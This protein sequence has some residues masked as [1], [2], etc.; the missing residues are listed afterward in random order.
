MSKVITK[1]E[2]LLNKEDYL[3]AIRDGAVFVYPTDTIY[4]VGCNACNQGAVERV[5][6]LKNRSVAPFSIIPPSQIWI[7]ENLELLSVAKEWL[8]KLPGPYTLILPQK[9]SDIAPSVTLANPD[10]GIRIPDHWIRVIVQELG[11]P[12]ITTSVNKAGD[13]FMR[14]IDDIDLDIK[15]GVDFIIDVGSK[16]AR[17]SQIVFL[18]KESIDIKRR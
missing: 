18:N 5:R 1:E 3:Q 6:E 7:Q 17:P 4:G 12:L 14:S 15:E 2:F 16:K 8:A 9:N 11:V 10:L 13:D